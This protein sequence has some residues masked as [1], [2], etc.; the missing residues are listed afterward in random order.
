MGNLDRRIDPVTKDYVLDGQGGCELTSTAEVALYLQMTMHLDEYWADPELGSNLH[1]FA[2]LGLSDAAL[3]FAQEDVVAALGLLE[4]AGM[5]RDIAV[6]VSIT[7][8]RPHRLCIT[9]EV[10]DTKGNRITL[11]EASGL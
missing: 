9:S 10:T 4:E 2:T 8:T 6:D 11:K 3:Q 1:R 7:D 5:I